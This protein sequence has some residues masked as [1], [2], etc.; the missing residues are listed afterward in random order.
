VRLRGRDGDRALLPQRARA[1]HLRGHDPDP[2]ADAGRTRARLPR[3]ERA[4]RGRVG[5]V[6][7]GGRGPR[8]APLHP[9][10]RPRSVAGLRGSVTG[11]SGSGKSTFARALAERLGVPYVELDALHHGPGWSETPADEF[12]RRVEEAIAAAPDGWVIDGNYRQK[13]DDLVLGAADTL[14]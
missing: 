2:Q 7:L 8:P 3:P 10:R 11:I 1:D 13:L 12:R 6:A 4:R 5:A 14:V 9:G